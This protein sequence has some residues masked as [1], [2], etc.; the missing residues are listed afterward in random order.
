MYGMKIRDYAKLKDF[1]VVGKLTLKSVTKEWYNEIDDRNEKMRYSF[2][3]DEAGNEYH[4]DGV[5][6]TADGGV[7]V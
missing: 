2:W 6:I 3:V 1:D 5:I 7:V 4:R